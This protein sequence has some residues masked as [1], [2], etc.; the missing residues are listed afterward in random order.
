MWNK[1][2]PLDSSTW[3]PAA[4]DVF[5]KITITG[6]SVFRGT[7]LVGSITVHEGRPTVWDPFLRTE[8]RRRPGDYRFVDKDTETVY[9]MSIP[10]VGEE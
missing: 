10:D 7:H 6:V 1:F 4:E 9:W 2:D 3:P 8:D 5:W